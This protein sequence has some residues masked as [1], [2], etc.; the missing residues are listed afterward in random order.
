MVGIFLPFVG[1]VVSRPSTGTRRR[2][3]SLAPSAL[4]RFN[5][6]QSAPMGTAVTSI[7]QRS[8]AAAAGAP[9]TRTLP[10]PA[11]AG[12]SELSAALTLG[13]SLERGTS[14]GTGRRGPRTSGLPPRRSMATLKAWRDVAVR[15]GAGSRSANGEM[16]CRL[17]WRWLSPP[18]TPSSSDPGNSS[19]SMRP[20]MRSRTGGARS[21]SST[22]SVLL[23]RHLRSF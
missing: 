17:R 4:V 16:R 12:G 22:L 1:G 2:R 20:S 6:A 11:L 18:G 19:R 15:L 9:A 8:E 3:S 21:L 23:D 14:R 10:I 13:A 5:R 7:A